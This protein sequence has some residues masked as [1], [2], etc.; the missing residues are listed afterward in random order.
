MLD[1]TSTLAGRDAV[2]GSAPDIV[3]VRPLVEVDVQLRALRRTG[4]LAE[5]D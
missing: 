4:A 2:A 5:R 3:D 1:G